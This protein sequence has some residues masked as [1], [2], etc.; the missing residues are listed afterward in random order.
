MW[1]LAM[2]HRGLLAVCALFLIVC[3]LALDDYGI[4]W[5][6]GA[7]RAIGNATL[8]YFVG[9]DERALDQLFFSHDRYY[10]AAFEAPLVFVERLLALEDSRNIYLSRHFLTHLIFLTSGAFCYLLVYRVF[11]SRPL[12]LV[13]MLLFLLHPR[14][15]AHSFFNSKD[16]PFAAMFMIALYLTHRSF[17]RDTLAAFLVCGVGVGVLVN[18]RIMGIVL[19]AAVLALR[20]LD[21]A[22]ASRKE[23]RKR[24]LAT[25]GAFALGAMLTYYAAL[26]GIWTDPL[27]QFVE[28]IQ[29][30]VNHPNSA[31]NFFRGEWLSSRDGPPF[32]YVPIWIGITTPPVVLLLAVVGVVWL[33]WRGARRPRDVW[34]AASPRFALLM[35]VLL[36]APIVFVF[37]AGSNIYDGWR[38]VFF[39]YVP[40]V[41]LATVGLYWLL[42]SVR[43]RWM[44]AGAFLAIGLSV[45]VTITS[46][47][48]IHPLQDSYFN[49]LVD[50]TTPDHL[51]SQYEMDY[52]ALGHW[53]LFKEA[54]DDHPEQRV[55][56]SLWFVQHQK[57]LLPEQ[58]RNRTLESPRIFSNDFY[59]DYPVS[60]S[61]Y[62]S[63]IY[64]NTIHTIAGVFLEQIDSEEIVQS[65]LSGDPVARSFFT[66]YL[67]ESMVIFV[68]EDC[69]PEQLA[70]R[71]FFDV[72]PVVPARLP[73][74]RKPFGF[75]R[76]GVHPGK[77]VIDVGGRCAWAV[78]LPD[79]PIA[80]IRTGQYDETGE[81]WVVEFTLPVGE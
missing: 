59:S 27:G 54:L 41:F 20:V 61:E 32:E 50:R 43:A 18:L 57:K 35:A 26:P 72:Y 70:A 22:L 46:L 79:Y 51:A 8:D 75:E 33:L 73:G 56:S 13:A 68:R 12:A 55:F 76:I 7:Q 17:R 52:W 67:H 16:V 6:A 78:L 5:D 23:D 62:T 47:A 60:N 1:R 14:L 31:E 71:F 34:Q 2:A 81:R 77:D 58:D 39:L 11:G 25:M 19:F 30:I 80:S 49:A 37:A 40:L 53:R 44:R 66:I 21:L 29:T 64:N 45:A 4:S 48:R 36:V 63:K 10:G 9:G 42:S 15:Y 69:S 28:A 38:Q 3:A 65:A 74:W 24:I